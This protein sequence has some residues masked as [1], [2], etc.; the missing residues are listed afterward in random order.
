HVDERGVIAIA[1]AYHQLG[2]LEYNA[3]SDAYLQVRAA[4][5]SLVKDAKWGSSADD[6]ALAVGVDSQFNHLVAGFT[7]GKMDANRRR[8]GRDA[9]V[10][11][12][13]D[14][15]AKPIWTRQWGSSGNDSAR[16]L[17]LDTADEIF[18]V[19]STN[20]QLDTAVAV[21]MEDIFVTKLDSV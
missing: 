9:F 10:R 18:I 16:A 8:G 5:G 21:G 14:D 13:G 3:D 2:L 6:A 15:P 1:G 11:K 4:D 19:G 20:G 17:V 12:W 7:A